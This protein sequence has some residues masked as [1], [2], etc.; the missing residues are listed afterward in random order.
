MGSISALLNFDNWPLEKRNLQG[1]KN[2]A[3]AGFLNRYLNRITQQL[4]LRICGFLV[5]SR[6]TELYR[7]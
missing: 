7:Q 6:Q 3:I 5:L 2:P 1:K 4:C